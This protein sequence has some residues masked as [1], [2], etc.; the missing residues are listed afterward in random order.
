MGGIWDHRS[1]ENLDSFLR[2]D[3]EGIN[4]PSRVWLDDNIRG[5][6]LDCGCGAGL[7]YE[8]LHDVC[9]YTGMDFTTKMLEICRNRFPEGNFV[10]GNVYSIPFPDKSFDIVFC[11]HLL[12][13][14]E[15]PKKAIDEMKRVGK[16]VIIVLFRPISEEHL[17]MIDGITP[18]NNYDNKLLDHLGEHKSILLGTEPY[19]HG[20]DYFQQILIWD[21][22]KVDEV[23][24]TSTE[25][26]AVIIK[27]FERVNPIIKC[28]NSILK[29]MPYA[30]MYIADDSH[31]I[32]ETKKKLYEKIK[33]MGHTV[34]RLPYD[35]GL[36]AGRNAC[37]DKITEKYTLVCDDD[38]VVEDGKNI[39]KAIGKLDS[40]INI[41]CG[42]L[43]RTDGEPHEDYNYKLH[44]KEKNLF[45][46]NVT[47]PIVNGLQ[48]VGI[49]LN[50]MVA[51][52]KTFKEIRW[53]D[54]LKL[55]EHFDFF[56]RAKRYGI[57]F[58]KDMVAVHDEDKT[59]K[60]YNELRWRK[61]ELYK[62][63]HKWLLKRE[64]YPNGDC[65][66]YDSLANSHIE[67]VD[68]FY[69]NCNN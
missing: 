33:K 10:E 32:N 62:F 57:Y 30:K 20:K 24:E 64:I 56:L 35:S 40:Y 4:N 37:L 58:F 47:T 66:E 1:K 65:L 52:T 22:P 45:I 29:S 28:V 61:D 43:V 60:T 48:Q 18:D 6:V 67:N 27:T 59:N 34:I 41:I 3:N 50:F 49:G 9:D 69:N 63:T 51:E 36:S 42:S 44:I 31:A 11:R 25:D 5:K 68:D 23:K 19:G 16:R 14:L 21:E 55:G 17:T 7:E 2:E 46:R 26:V 53:D 38:F 8:A 39:Q 54:N 12:E 13:H 15:D